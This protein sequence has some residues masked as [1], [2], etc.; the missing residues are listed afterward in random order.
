MCPDAAQLASRTHVFLLTQPYAQQDT[1]PQ[2]LNH[3][4]DPRGVITF[5]DITGRGSSL[6]CGMNRCDPNALFVGW[7]SRDK[8]SPF[9]SGWPGTY[10]TPGPR[11]YRQ[12]SPPRL[13]MWNLRVQ[14]E[15][16]EQ[17]SC[18]RPAIST[19]R[20]QPHDRSASH[21]ENTGRPTSECCDGCTLS[22][23]CI[24]WKSFLGA[25]CRVSREVI[26]IQG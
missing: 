21:E 16:L 1:F 5:M 20:T 7:T 13:T 15:E 6:A 9:S 11:D 22:P 18:P 25:V 3:S 4:A 24:C 2:R 14:A 12:S 10:G 19:V 23:R 17:G 26:L 8:V